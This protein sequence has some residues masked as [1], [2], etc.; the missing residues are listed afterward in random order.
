MDNGRLLRN[1]KRRRGAQ[2]GGGGDVGEHRVGATYL[3]VKTS[4]LRRAAGAD[5][6]R[7]GC[8]GLVDGRPGK[9]I[10]LPPRARVYGVGGAETGIVVLNENASGL[11][12]RGRSRNISIETMGKEHALLYVQ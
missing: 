10:S 6:L 1:E 5:V 9:A 12:I 4:L 11:K 3:V 8:A 7:F 2:P